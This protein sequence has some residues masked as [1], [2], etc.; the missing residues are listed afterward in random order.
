MDMKLVTHQT[1][2]FNSGPIPIKLL[3]YDTTEI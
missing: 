2:T 3:F 1:E